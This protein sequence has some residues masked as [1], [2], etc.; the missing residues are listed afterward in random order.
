MAG[1]AVRLT[2]S[3]GSGYVEVACMS[4]SRSRSKTSTARSRVSQ[5]DMP[6]EQRTGLP[7]AAM[8]RS[9][10]KNVS[11]AEANLYVSASNS[12]TRKST[13]SVSHGEAN[14]CSPTSLE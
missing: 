5:S 2:S 12:L 7:V 13:E 11:E 6:E 1:I 3:G 4:T 14:H 10:S 8:D 9:S